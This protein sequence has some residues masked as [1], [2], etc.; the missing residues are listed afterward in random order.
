M[1]LVYA[2]FLTIVLVKT[3]GFYVKPSFLSETQYVNS[4]VKQQFLSKI[5]PG[6]RVCLISKHIGV[7]VKDE[8]IVA[9]KYAFVYSSYFHPEIN[10]DYSIQ[11]ALQPKL[12]GDRKIIPLYFKDYRYSK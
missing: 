2:I 7:N 1:G 10:Y 3:Q 11:T 5:Q 4:G 8:P 6:D 9:L 12:C